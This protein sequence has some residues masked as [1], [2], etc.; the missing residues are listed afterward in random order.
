VAYEEDEWW[1]AAGKEGGSDGVG[2]W[3]RIQWRL[4]AMYL[5]S[6]KENQNKIKTKS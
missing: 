2:R 3:K 1:L 6:K 5:Q 4:P